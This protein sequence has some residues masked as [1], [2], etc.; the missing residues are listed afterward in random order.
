MLREELQGWSRYTLT[1]TQRL[2]NHC[3]WARSYRPLCLVVKITF[4]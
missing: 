4:L 1:D 2:H 3:K